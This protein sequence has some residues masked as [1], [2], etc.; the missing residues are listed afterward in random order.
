LDLAGIFNKRLDLGHLVH[1]TTL[2]LGLYRLHLFLY[3]AF[4]IKVIF[5]VE[6]AL[7]PTPNCKVFGLYNLSII[8]FLVIVKF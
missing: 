6:E 2:S 4:D 3:F 1:H 7:G 5:Q 8:Q